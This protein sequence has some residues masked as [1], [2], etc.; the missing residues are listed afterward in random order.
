MTKTFE[1]E[2]FGE[3]SDFRGAFGAGQNKQ[4]S[5]QVCSVG[6]TPHWHDSCFNGNEVKTK[7][8]VAEADLSSH[9]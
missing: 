7:E 3:V 6:R 5:T 2:I 8:S 9:F 4:E 1:E